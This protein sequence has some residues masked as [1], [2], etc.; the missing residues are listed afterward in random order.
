MVHLGRFPHTPV[1]PPATLLRQMR[2]GDI[3]THAFRGGGGM[4]DADGKVVG[5]LRDALDRGVVLDLGHSGTDFRFREARRLMD[6][7]VV[8]DTASTDLNVFNLDGPVFSITENLTKLLALGMA[9]SDVVATATTNP[10]RAIHR[11]ASLGALAPGRRAE[12]SVLR[13]RTDGP[14]PVTDGHEVVDS[15]AA[16]EPVG[17]MR[18]GE[19]IPVPQR[20]PSYAVDGWSPGHRAE[21]ED[22]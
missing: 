18:A 14:F 1:I 15:P 6:Q 19:W 16:F 9:V 12:I 20:V 13:L 17:C 21:D 5:E 10:A 11:E 7:G 4:L 22:W 3:V 2:P 8:P